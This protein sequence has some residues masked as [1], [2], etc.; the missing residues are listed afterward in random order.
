MLKLERNLLIITAIILSLL[1]LFFVF[2]SSALESFK[3]DGTPFYLVKNQ[4]IGFGVGLVALLIASFIP[5]RWYLKIPYVFYF[6]AI[7]LIGLC[8]FD[9]F[10]TILQGN[11]VANGARRWIYVFGLSVQV[12]EIVKFCMIIFFSYL[13][14]KIKDY[15][16]FLLYLAPIA[17]LILMQKDLGSLIVMVAICFGLYFLSGAPMKK[18]FFIGTALFVAGLMM[19]V[20]SPYRRERLMTYLHPDTNR[21]GDAYHVDQLKIAIGRGEL[22][23]KGI[24]QSRQK[25]AYVPEVAT[26]SIFS[27]VAEEI[28]FIGVSFI[29]AI[30]MFFL[31]L[32]WRI[33]QLAPLTE[34]EKMVGYGV[35]LLFLSQ[36]FINLGAISGLLPLTGITLP[37]FSAGGSSLV[38][39]LFLVGVV[40]S[41]S[42]QTVPSIIKRKKYV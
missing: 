18:I 8:F 5:V 21:Q 9:G 31:F 16:I 36:I 22:T 13:V 26:D 35:F 10:G 37:F 17:A 38:I 42:N 20:A 25:F 4:A 33:T 34:M 30:Y 12:A 3:Q 23:G 19:I 40:V 28:G 39:S 27:I 2:E 29:F 6:L 41:L 15:R 32:I 11:V 24:G 1:G 7:I 14:L